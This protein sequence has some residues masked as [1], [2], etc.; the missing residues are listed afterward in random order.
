M[1]IGFRPR[2]KARPSL[3]D[4]VQKRNIEHLSVQRH[5][6]LSLELPELL[7]PLPPST[8][9]TPI[10][11]QQPQSEYQLPVVKMAP[12]KEEKKSE[13]VEEQTGE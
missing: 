13:D 1:N 7:P 12:K 9:G 11:Y 10:P 2:L 5:R 6:S 3:Y 4:L 8:P